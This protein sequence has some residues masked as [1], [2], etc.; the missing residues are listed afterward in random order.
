LPHTVLFTHAVN[1]L[2]FIRAL[3]FLSR[4]KKINKYVKVKEINSR[5][6]SR[7]R[8]N[9]GKGISPEENWIFMLKNLLFGAFLRDF[10][11]PWLTTYLLKRCLALLK[12]FRRLLFDLLL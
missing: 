8:G 10:S 7:A 9:C 5:S 11:R 1:F 3:R 2:L 6:I 4:G 12:Y